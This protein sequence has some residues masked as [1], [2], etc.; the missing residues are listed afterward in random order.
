MKI[1]QTFDFPSISLSNV[2]PPHLLLRV[3]NNQTS[4]GQDGGGAENW[5]EWTSLFVCPPVPCRNP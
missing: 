5:H 2:F 1:V 4:Q 3:P